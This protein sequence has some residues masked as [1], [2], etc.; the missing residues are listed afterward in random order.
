MIRSGKLLLLCVLLMLAGCAKPKP[1]LR[2][3]WPA[4][5]DRPRLEWI[6][7]FHS[8]DNFPKTESEKATE[9]LLGKGDQHYFGKPM[10]VASA[11][12]GVVYV[13]DLDVHNIRVIDFNRRKNELFFKQPV[14]GLPIGLALDSRG[15]LYVSDAYS[16]QIWVVSVETRKPIMTFGGDVFK[17]PT[18]M[19]LNERLGRLYVSDVKDHVVRVFDLEGKHLFDFGKPGGEEGNLY[20]PQGIAIDKDDNVFVAEQF[21][22]RVQVFDADGNY[23]YRF[24]TRG[25]QLFQFEGPRGLAF[26][27]EGHLYVAETRKA[28][29]LIFTPDGKPLTA[30]GGKRTTHQLGF[31]LP[32]AIYIDRNDRIYITDGMNKRLTIWQYLTP[33]YLEKHPLDPKLM[34]QL[35]EKTRRLLEEKK[36]Q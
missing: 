35:E 13:A 7:S 3:L 18:F 1:P 34:R 29:L 9:A 10:G 27:S 30:I 25:D 26:D 24:G 11:G 16:K 19:A 15:R 20:G 8:E 31:A 21:N 32:N 36:A 23:K 22:A 2:V 28:A 12:D 5:P 4:P 17:K 14:I 6:V 33:D